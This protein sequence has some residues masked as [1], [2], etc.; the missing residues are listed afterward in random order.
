MGSG[1]S[2][3]SAA[4]NACTAH[5]ASTERSRADRRGESASSDTQC[6]SAR[7]RTWDGASAG[8]AFAAAPAIHGLRKRRS[9]PTTARP[10][11]VGTDRTRRRGRR[12]EAL[13]D[14]A[15]AV[16]QARVELR[17]VAEELVEVDDVEQRRPQQTIRL[18]LPEGPCGQPPHGGT[19]EQPLARGEARHALV[20]VVHPRLL[21][22]AG[23]RGAGR[24]HRCDRR[25]GG[26]ERARPERPSARL[27]AASSEPVARRTARRTGS[28]GT[29]GSVVADVADVAGATA[30]EA[31]RTGE[32]RRR[33]SVRR[34]GV[35]RGSAPRRAS[36]GGR[37]E[38]RTRLAVV[39]GRAA[40]A[41]IR[42]R[43]QRGPLDSASSERPGLIPRASGA[44]A[45]R[46]RGRTRRCG[47]RHPVQVSG[48][49]SVR[50]GSRVHWGCSP[51]WA[52]V[53]ATSAP[54]ARMSASVPRV[55]PYCGC[56]SSA[57]LQPR[58]PAGC[59]RR[60][61]VRLTGG[62]NASVRAP[63]ERDVDHLGGIAG[64]LGMEPGREQRVD[65]ADPDRAGAL[66]AAVHG[67][68]P[69][70]QGGAPGGG[71]LVLAMV[72]HVSTYGRLVAASS[73]MSRSAWRPQVL[74]HAKFWRTSRPDRRSVTNAAS[75][76]VGR[77][78][79][80]SRRGAGRPRP[81]TATRK[82]R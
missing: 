80:A 5:S 82:R 62:R 7:R 76:Q 59:T 31:I 17:G 66:V 22:Q 61:V 79:A 70:A 36:A 53:R 40:R 52:S 27:R 72:E 32:I 45:R 37:T 78:G 68:V 2:A 15:G 50:F 14:R 64:P 67:A 9:V 77:F 57:G 43:E 25:T 42:G 75:R 49:Q 21:K 63:L 10:S 6:R 74:Q 16:I 41:R 30:E 73:R 56:T 58:V 60:G 65:D 71:I 33:G 54:T 51:T 69:Q 18:R 81:T 1:V 39:T 29:G 4:S 47:G 34:G 55:L 12:G 44:N 3:L 24:P 23:G 8:L 35:R 38:H 11:A 13:S 46:Q 28:A 48:T 26:A 19:L 20:R